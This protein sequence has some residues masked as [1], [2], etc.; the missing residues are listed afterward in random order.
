MVCTEAW[1][2]ETVHDYGTRITICNINGIMKYNGKIL[3]KYTILENDIPKDK[4]SL[5]ITKNCTGN[6]NK[7]G[8]KKINITH[9]MTKR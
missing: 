4:I 2:N 9:K 8:I 5:Y 6:Y 7:C 3:Y 1:P